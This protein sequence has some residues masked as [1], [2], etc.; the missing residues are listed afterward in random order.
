[1]GYVPDDA[2]WW[3]AEIVEEITVEDDARNVVH[4][5]FKPPGNVMPQP[6]LPITHLDGPNPCA[7]Q[8]RCELVYQDLDF[9]KFR[10]CIDPCAGPARRS[11]QRRRVPGE[12]FEHSR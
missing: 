8:P 7:L 10:Q 4:I 5:N 12:G 2:K 11:S 6:N 1:M 9:R 3:I